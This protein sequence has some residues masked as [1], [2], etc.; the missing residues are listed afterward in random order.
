MASV[1]PV[2]VAKV[3]FVCGTNG[4]V[5]QRE[6]GG[7]ELPGV[8]DATGIGMHALLPAPSVRATAS[9]DD[10]GTTEP[11]ACSLEWRENVAAVQSVDP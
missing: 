2:E 5:E 3:T 7:Y 9:G 10:R 6:P 11:L 8:S 4:A 1:N